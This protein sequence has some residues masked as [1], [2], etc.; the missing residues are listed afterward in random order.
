M[1]KQVSIEKIRPNRD[2]KSQMNQA[3]KSSLFPILRRVCA[4]PGVHDVCGSHHLVA[5]ARTTLHTPRDRDALRLACLCAL[6]ASQQLE[7]TVCSW[8]LA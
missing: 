5:R 8:L 3:K 4:R 6:Q 1:A 2:K 7:V